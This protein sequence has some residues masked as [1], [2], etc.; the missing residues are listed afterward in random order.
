MFRR[1]E[2]TLTAALAT[3]LLATAAL[4]EGA[5]AE[6]VGTYVWAR[7][8][9]D[10]GG[11][12]G[13]DIDADGLAFR[14]VSDIGHTRS[15]TLIRD[16]EERVAGVRSGPE[17]H[18][19][20]AAGNVLDDKHWDAEGLAILPD[21]SFA[22][23][24]ERADRI[25]LFDAEGRYLSSLTEG[26][27][28]SNLVPNKGFEALAT[29][30]AGRLFSIPEAPTAWGGPFPV[31]VS[32]GAAWSVPM[33]IPSAGRWRP[34]GADFGP[35]GR[36]Y[37]VERDYWGLVGFMTRIR[38]LT[39][40]GTTIV[41]DEVLAETRARVHDNLESIAA[42]RGADG[43]VRLTLISDDNRVPTQRTEFVDYVVRD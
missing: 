13:L 21:G 14:V 26:T 22:V 39:L 34:V 35:D 24:F 37:I 2:V 31:H 6:W 20:D 40:D 7:D 32:D 5:E 29:D 42:W 30:G 43:R 12:S 10:F 28:L 4:S 36:L 18:L 33:S 38:R 1:P 25:D 41:A 11:Y 9:T 23:A 3:C 8:G 19:P 27:D 15:G 17:T 16:A